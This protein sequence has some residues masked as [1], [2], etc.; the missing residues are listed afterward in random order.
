VG[1]KGFAPV[2]IIILVLIALVGAYYFGTKKGNIL[3]TPSQTP[4]QITTTPFP[5]GTK[6]VATSSPISTKTEVKKL[7]TDFLNAVIAQNA[8][9]ARS[10]LTDALKIE[11]KTT[12]LPAGYKTFEILN[13]FHSTEEE[14]VFY[15]N[16]KLLFD[17]KLYQDNDP[18]GTIFILPVIKENNS[19]KIGT[20]P[21]QPK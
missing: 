4:I 3:P 19:W 15:S 13:E 17:V 10:Y 20:W 12:A 11:Y 2:L 1:Q 16:S 9:K 5:V 6:T 7:I 21:P 18:Q 8:D 14:S